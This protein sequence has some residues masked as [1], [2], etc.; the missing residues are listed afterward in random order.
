[1]KNILFVGSLAVKSGRLDG[2][3]IKCK[4]YRC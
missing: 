2:V 1:M 3:T 4:N